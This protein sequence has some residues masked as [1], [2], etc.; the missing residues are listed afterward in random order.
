MSTTETVPLGGPPTVLTAWRHRADELADMPGVRYQVEVPAPGDEPATPDLARHLFDGGA[1]RVALAAPITLTGGDTATALR[2]VALVRDLTSVGIAIDWTLRLPD[3]APTD[4]DDEEN[5]W[6][7]GGW[8]LI[9]HLHPPS[10]V[11]AGGAGDA[12]A[13]RTEWAD[14]YFFG[15]FMYR[16]GPGFVQVRDR[17]LGT[18]N[19]FTVDD[20][21]YLAAIR[22]LTPGTPAAA[23][24]PDVLAAFRDEGLV[25]AAGG[26]ALWLPYRVRRWPWHAMTV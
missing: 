17:R 14:T 25:W 20:P 23:V 16:R 10:Q 6:G 21:A 13:V 1:R 19:R 26:V 7:A 4:D 11:D 2:M 12:D 18:L 9:S 22:T 8:R 15:R 3:R 5:R 24:R